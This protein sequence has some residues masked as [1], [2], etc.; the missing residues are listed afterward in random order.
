MHRKLTAGV[1]LAVRS[2]LLLFLDEEQRTYDRWKESIAHKLKSTR[3]SQVDRN[4]RKR[5]QAIRIVIWIMT[6]R[7]LRDDDMPPLYES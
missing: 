6:P 3:R 5:I 4:F 2:R 1:R 7:E